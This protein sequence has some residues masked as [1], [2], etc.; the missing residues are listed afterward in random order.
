[1]EIQEGTAAR[2]P[3]REQLAH[4]DFPN[5]AVGETSADAG[6]ATEPTGD[7]T[8]KLNK[9]SISYRFWMRLDH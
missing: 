9:T 7:T 6:R 5:D 8:V 1:M 2:Y 3:V 4:L